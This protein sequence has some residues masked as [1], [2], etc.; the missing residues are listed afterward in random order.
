MEFADSC[1]M[2]VGNTYF[3]KDDEKLRKYKCGGNAT[4]LDCILFKKE[5]F[6]QIKDVKV[7]P[8]E[9]YFTQQR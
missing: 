3:Q 7:I 4:V 8:G 5:M 2:I 9:E 6:R 1:G